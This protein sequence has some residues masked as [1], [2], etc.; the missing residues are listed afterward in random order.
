MKS[1]KREINW[2]IYLKYVMFVLW[3]FWVAFNS[4]SRRKVEKVGIIVQNI[5]DFNK[6]FIKSPLTK[7]AIAMWQICTFWQ[8]LMENRLILI[9]FIHFNSYSISI[10]F[11]NLFLLSDDFAKMRFQSIWFKYW[12]KKNLQ[13]HTWKIE[14]QKQNNDVDYDKSIVTTRHKVAFS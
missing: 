9:W 14:N 5:V 1:D 6:D 12:H 4:L 2:K 11:M 3:S 10:K 8:K 13:K 7:T